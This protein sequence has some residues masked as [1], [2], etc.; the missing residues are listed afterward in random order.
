MG[1]IKQNIHILYGFHNQHNLI[2]AH[3]IYNFNLYLAEKDN[4]LNSNYTQK[5]ILNPEMLVNV[6]NNYQE[7][8]LKKKLLCF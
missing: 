3:S 8:I 4:L 7:Q 2:L 1:H 6:T 5:D